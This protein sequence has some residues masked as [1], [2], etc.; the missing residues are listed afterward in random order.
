M[1]RE[2]EQYQAL[3]SRVAGSSDGGRATSS[4][5]IAL[6]VIVFLVLTVSVICIK[7]LFSRRKVAKMMSE[8]RLADERKIQALEDEELAEC[9]GERLAAQNVVAEA[10]ERVEELKDQIQER[11]WEHTKLVG[12]LRAVTNWDDLEVIDAREDS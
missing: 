4:F 11:R 8:M 12:K 7:V 3:A 5:P 6:V 2:T 10:E 1:S 9:E